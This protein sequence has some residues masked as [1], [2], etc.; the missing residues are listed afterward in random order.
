M[1]SGF[2]DKKRGVA[3]RRNKA[4]GLNKSGETLKPGMRRMFETVERPVKKTNK[5]M[6]G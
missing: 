2:E 3:F 6:G 5:A 1:V 4:N